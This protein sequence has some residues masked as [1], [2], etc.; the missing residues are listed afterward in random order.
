M[1][2]RIGPV[3]LIVSDLEREIGFHCDVLGFK[4]H[5]RKGSEA[6]L[7]AGGEDIFRFTEIKGAQPAYRSTGLY[8]TAILV[9]TR[10]DLAQLLIRIVETRTPIQGASNHGTHLAIYLADAEENGIELAWDFPRAVWPDFS[11]LT[12]MD[13][14]EVQS[15]MSGPFD[16]EQF[17]T[18]MQP[19]LPIWSGLDPGTQV[20]HIHLKVAD[21]PSTSHFYHDILGFDITMDLEKFGA[22]FFST[23]GYHHRIGTNI[24]ESRGAPPPPEGSTGLQYFTV[25]FPDQAT[26]DT[27]VNNLRNG[28]VQ[29]EPSQ[30]GILTCDPSQNKIL[31]ISEE[32]LPKTD[33]AD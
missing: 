6:G 4:L 7:G 1:D 16:L 12:N 27:T 18:E 2:A 28:G 29:A 33:S 31:L 25:V 15:F 17:L 32:N 9:P 20:G 24:W 3:S 5:W 30:G 14:R 11:N 10:E 13:P 23:S 21:L 19:Q 26:F 8:H 22:L